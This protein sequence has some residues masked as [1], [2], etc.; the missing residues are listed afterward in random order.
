MEKEQ[1]TQWPKEKV[2]K[3]K[4]RSTKHYINLKIDQL[5]PHQKLVVNSGDPEGWAIPAPQVAAVKLRFRLDGCIWYACKIVFL[6]SAY[7]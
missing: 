5:E 4:H 6:F 7:M 3:D 1:T 2:Q